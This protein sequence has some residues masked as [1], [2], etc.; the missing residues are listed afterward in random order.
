MLLSA[1]TQDVLVYILQT[2]AYLSVTLAQ[3]HRM[4]CNFEQELPD[5]TTLYLVSLFLGRS[6]AAHNGPFS[7]RPSSAKSHRSSGRNERYVLML[8]GATQAACPG[9]RGHQ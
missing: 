9:L 6:T 2:I 7:K 5:P 8:M 3:F 4:G 1:Q